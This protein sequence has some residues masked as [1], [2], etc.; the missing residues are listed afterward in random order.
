MKYDMKISLPFYKVIYSVAFMVILLIIRGI[1]RAG[2]VIAALEPNVALLAGIFLADNYYKEFSNGNIQ[3]FYRYPLQKKMS[4]VLR[5]NMIGSI[6]LWLLTVVA[7]FAYMFVYHPLNTSYNSISIMLLF[8]GMLT[9]T[10][11]NFAQN[12]GIGIGIFIIFWICLTSKFAEYLPKCL[13]LFLL[14][15]SKQQLGT[16]TPYYQSR[17][18]YLLITIILIFLNIYTLNMEPKY[19][20]REWGVKHEYKN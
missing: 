13:R 3:V 1:S 7:Y 10:V 15:E 4:A 8:S 20:K 17:F 19:K 9:F 6:Y 12:I 11:T 2:E 16:F 5:R 14:E 18:L